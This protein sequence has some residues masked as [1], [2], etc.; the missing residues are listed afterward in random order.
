MATTANTTTATTTSSTSGAR[1]PTSNRRTQQPWGLYQKKNQGNWLL[2]VVI[3]GKRVT[4]ST[5]TCDLKL[6]I[7]RA[8]DLHAAAMGDLAAPIP[9]SQCW[10]L[11]HA[12]DEFIADKVRSGSPENTTRNYRS[13]RNTFLGVIPAA[14]KLTDLSYEVISSFIDSQLAKGRKASTI[15]YSLMLLTVILRY[16]G[17][18]GHYAGDPRRLFPKGIMKKPEPRKRFLH[19]DEIGK[20]LP[21]CQPNHRDYVIAYLYTGCRKRELFRICPEHVNLTAG[22][23]EVP[24]TKTGESHGTMPLA[25]PLRDVLARRMQSTPKGSPIFPP[26]NDLNKCISRAARR[27]GLQHLT[28][29]DL[30]RTTGSL[31]ASANVSLQIIAGL[32][33]H[34]SVETTSRT[35]AHLVPSAGVDALAL[36]PTIGTDGKV[37]TAKGSKQKPTTNAATVIGTAQRRPGSRRVAQVHRDTST[38]IALH[39]SLTDAA[40]ALGIAANKIGDVCAGRQKS[41]GGFRWMYVDSDQRDSHHDMHQDAA[42]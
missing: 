7:K 25:A 13:A 10:T 24:G 27:A 4:K 29:H 5:G 37:R 1:N 11:L 41:A 21:E 40:R 26:L 6:A 33:R 22:T 15:R 16:A 23:V 36:L 38:V 18:R 17:D 28:C 42:E 31:L 30:R 8:P 35:Y 32:L 2:P 3:G 34:K 19:V 9:P 39:A 12:F 14:T 20:L